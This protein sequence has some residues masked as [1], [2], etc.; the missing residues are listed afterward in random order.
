MNTPPLRPIRHRSRPAPGTV[1][2]TETIADLRNLTARPSGSDPRA[3]LRA[4]LALM[5]SVPVI[6]RIATAQTLGGGDGQDVPANGA[7]LLR[8]CF[9]MAVGTI[10]SLDEALALGASDV[11]ASM[12]DRRLAVRAAREFLCAHPGVVAAHVPDFVPT[13]RGPPVPPLPNYRSR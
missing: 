8:V 7:V 2:R 11:E 6:D 10:A 1:A 5:R 13:H 3:K 9:W 12:R 4:A